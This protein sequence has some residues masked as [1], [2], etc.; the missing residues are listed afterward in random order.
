MATA[1]AAQVSSGLMDRLT[2]QDIPRKFGDSEGYWT[3]Y[4]KVAGTLNEDMLKALRTNLDNLLVFVSEQGSTGT[5]AS[6]LIEI[7]T[8]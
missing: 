3:H 7:F 4:D 1:T 8:R 2:V 5:S 6:I